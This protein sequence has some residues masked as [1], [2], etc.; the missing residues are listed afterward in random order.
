[1][2]EIVSEQ[3][4][5]RLNDEEKQMLDA[6]QKKRP[7]LSRAGCFIQM[8][9]ETTWQAEENGKTARLTRIEAT[10]AEH[11]A[12]LRLLCDKLN[13]EDVTP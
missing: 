5:V 8:L 2:A 10:L 3:V 13:V 11:G 1:M 9:Y 4:S 6:Y 7:A 12:L